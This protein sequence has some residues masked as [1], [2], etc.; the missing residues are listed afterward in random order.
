MAEILV[1]AVDATHPDPVKDQRGCYKRGMFVAVKPDGW[2][3]GALERLPQFAIIK[4][5][6]IP[7]A[8]VE[9]YMA[10]VSETVWVEMPLD[11]NP[12][13]GEWKERVTRR[14]RWQLRWADLPAAARNKLQDTGQL[15]IKAGSYGGAYD[16]TWPQVRGYLRD[17]VTGLDET[18]DL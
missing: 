6:T 12:A 15:V 1:K 9:K 11:F 4:I 5:P 18:G 3:W 7:V 13:G 2:E 14:R 16:Y 8:T 17:L 10:S